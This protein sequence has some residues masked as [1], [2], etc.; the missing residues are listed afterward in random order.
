MRPFGVRLSIK[1]P[2][3]VLL[4]VI[5]TASTAGLLMIIVG[6]HVVREREVEANIS[7]RNEY[8]SAIA[9]YLD[10]ARSML[11]LTANDIGNRQLVPSGAATPRRRGEQPR[12]HPAVRQAAADIIDHTKRFEYVMFIGADG[13]VELVEPRA[14]QAD[15][16]RPDLA[17]PGW[18]TKV[19]STGNTVFGDLE[20]STVTR[21]P[22]VIVASPVKGP[23]GEILGI[24]AGGL[25]LEQLSLIGMEGTDRAKAER[26]GYVTDP[27]GIIIAHQENRKFVEE[28]TDFSTVPPVRA[29]LAGEGGARQFFSPIRAEEMLGAY[30]QLPDAGWAVVYVTTTRMAYAPIDRLTRLVL[31]AS[32]GVVVLLGLLGVGV[33]KRIVNPI[34]K[35]ASAAQA[36]GRGNLDQRIEV[37]TG[38]EIEML[39][40]EFNRMAGA[41]SEKEAQLRQRADQL[42]AANKELEAFSYSV[43]HDLRAPL[44]HVSGYIDLLKRNMSAA[45]DEKGRHY[46]EMITDSGV[47]MGRLIDD[48]LAFSRMG[49]EEMRDEKVSL[50]DLLSEVLKDFREE[51]RGRVIAWETE[52]LPEVRGDP[53]MLRAVLTNLVSNAVKFTRLR[54]EARIRIGWTEGEGREAVVFVRDNGV[55]FDMKYVD[56]LFGVFQRLHSAAEFEGTGVGLASVRRIVHRH[57]GKTWAEG[58]VG[59]GATFF[60]TI[61]RYGGE[62]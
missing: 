52:P 48:L 37:R 26:F 18:Y 45:L 30:K 51:T 3:F 39:A 2:A 21:K 42:E 8:A 14:L 29:A 61:R 1:L 62:T 44:R 59:E 50:G 31:L 32:L 43:S 13:F 6:R 47:K 12:G 33:V 23:K 9:F 15:L 57:G 28:Q 11:E 4:G 24:L 22:T 27:R 58:A 5:L 55:G 25:Q 60:F 49:R 20:I 54:P 40:D 38:D 35:M 56:K 17:F 19:M 46:I 7:S 41:L 34:G 16:S 10:G 53:S 36:I